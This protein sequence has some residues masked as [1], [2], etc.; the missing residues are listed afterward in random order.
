MPPGKDY[1]LAPL[2]VEPSVSAPGTGGARVSNGA[3]QGAPAGA[4]D[5]ELGAGDTV[6]NREVE[7]EAAT[8]DGPPA[9]FKKQAGRRSPCTC[10]SPTAVVAFVCGILAT[11]VIM[12]IAKDP[13]EI[14]ATSYLCPDDTG[15]G[16]GQGIAPAA[17]PMPDFLPETVKTALVALQPDLAQLVASIVAGE[18]RGDAYNRTAEFV[19]RF[20]H[21]QA[22]SASLEMSLD[23]L[24]DQLEE[25]GLENVRA[26]EVPVPRWV[27]GNESLHL[28]APLVGGSMR[29]MEI[30]GLGFSVGTQNEPDG[31]LEAEVVVVKTLEELV[32]RED[33]VNGRIVVFDMPYQG[34][35]KTRPYRTHTASFAA[36]LGARGLLL[37][38]VASFSLNSPHTGTMSYRQGS[39]DRATAD[40][41]GFGL[42][43][44]P[45]RL[46]GSY[47][48]V[49]KIPAAAITVEDAAML[50]RMEDRGERVR[51]RLQMAAHDAGEAVSRN[52][53]ADIV[54]SEKPDEV[55]VVSGHIDSWDVGQG[56]LDD[57]GPAFTALQTLLAVKDL[58][59]KPRRTLRMIFWTAE[60]IGSLGGR[61]YF[62]SRL[63][64]VEKLAMA[65]ELDF[66]IFNPSGVQ[67]RGDEL[68]TDIAKWVGSQVLPDVGGEVY[69]AP[70]FGT[71]DMY[72]WLSESRGGDEGIPALTLAHLPATEHAV[73]VDGDGGGPVW[74]EDWQ[75]DYFF[76][77]HTHADT[78][79]ILDPRQMDR[80]AAIIAAHA[81]AVAALPDMPTRGTPMPKGNTALAQSCY[82][83]PR[84]AVC[85]PYTQRTGIPR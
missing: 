7:D 65:V 83:Y 36:K 64:P 68:T 45:D 60:E 1:E 46:L 14:M 54:G 72:F 76:Y 10:L 28:V 4:F 58:N 84:S 48:N 5:A 41:A 12:A 16:G 9:V 63:L 59:L 49:P 50:H 78:M 82:S 22:G 73:R 25:L 51:V 35:S 33:E 37:R 20:G 8:D 61:A 23:F 55:V 44:V 29:K 26:F 2:E 70:T 18:R 80:A 11:L 81:Y 21:R 17:P 3:A 30:L 27:R 69:P 52:I 77:H 85:I 71:S 57:A 42:G 43:G 67:L 62:E 24:S 15:A 74:P 38:S 56:A 47:D 40:R 6:G 34:Y 66:G 79:H 19:D 53:M 13:I 31:S 32:E 75:G 39:L